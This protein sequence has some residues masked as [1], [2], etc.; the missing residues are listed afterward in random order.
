LALLVAR[1]AT[2]HAHHPLAANH[3]TFLAAAFYRSFDF[4]SIVT[5]TCTGR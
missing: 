4:H 3:F 2:N 1:V 5:L